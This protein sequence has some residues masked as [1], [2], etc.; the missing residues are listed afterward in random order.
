[1]AL[2]IGAA[3]F[4]PV[5]GMLRRDPPRTPAAVLVT[6]KLGLSAVFEQ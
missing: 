1:M 5:V 2:L 6:A 4:V 3:S